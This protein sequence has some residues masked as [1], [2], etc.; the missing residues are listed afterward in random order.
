MSQIV[1]PYQL[2]DGTVADA[3][4]VMSNYNAIVNVVNGNID[5]TNLASTIAITDSHLNQIQTAGKVNGTALTNLAGIPSGAGIIPAANLTYVNVQYPYVKVSETESSGTAGG[6]ATSGSWITRVLNTTDNDTQSI[7]SLSSNQ[8]TLPAGT[9]LTRVSAPFYSSVEGAQLR[10]QNITA[11][12]TLIIGQSIQI[13]NASG[14]GGTAFLVG[15]FTLSTSS[16]LA[17][18]YQVGSTINT[19]GLGIACSFGTEVYTVAEFTKIQ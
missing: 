3:S 7:S 10:L 19:N 15:L 16:A 1:L 12:T 11:S 5:N 4:Q 18:Q 13:A 14:F 17:V 8:I 2:Q 9:Y 6:T